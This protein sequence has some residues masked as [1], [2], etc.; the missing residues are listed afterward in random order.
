MEQ[1]TGLRCNLNSYLLALAP[2]VFLFGVLALRTAPVYYFFS[3]LNNNIKG[4]VGGSRK[5][6]SPFSFR[7]ESGR[8]HSATFTEELI[9]PNSLLIIIIKKLIK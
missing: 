4:W 9:S 2:T 1:K 5:C 3:F 7:I 6:V 8:L